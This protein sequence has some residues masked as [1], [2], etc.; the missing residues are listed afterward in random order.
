MPHKLNYEPVGLNIDFCFPEFKSKHKHKM[1][2]ESSLGDLGP[3]VRFYIM[4][5]GNNKW[6]RYT[7]V[8]DFCRDLGLSEEEVLFW[9]L[10]YGTN[11][12]CYLKDVPDY[13]SYINTI[14]N[15]I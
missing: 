9:T 13:E 10:K 2:L 15:Y 5:R 11:L 1:L 8:D 7:D 4:Q 12:P 3:L 14:K 6:Y